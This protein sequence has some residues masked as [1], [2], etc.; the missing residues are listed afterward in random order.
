MLPEFWTE[1]V[2]HRPG[3]AEIGVLSGGSLLAKLYLSDSLG[4]KVS[5]TTKCILLVRTN[6]K[7][8]RLPLPANYCTQISSLRLSFPFSSSYISLLPHTRKSRSPSMSKPL[9]IL[10]IMASLFRT[11]T[12][13]SH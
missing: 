13:S 9:T 1:V 5:Q 12:T 2:A 11:F 10:Q 6:I 8:I 7:K 3:E 4:D